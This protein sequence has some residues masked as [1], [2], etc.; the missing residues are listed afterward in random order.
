[1]TRPL[2]S[3]RLGLAV[4]IAALAVT[5]MSLAATAGPAGA[6]TAPAPTTATTSSGS[7]GGSNCIIASCSTVAKGVEC[8]IMPSACVAQAVV[9][10]VSSQVADAVSSMADAMMAALVKG[11]A[12]G[13]TAMFAEVGKFMTG[14][15]TPSVS[16]ADFVSGDGPYHKVAAVSAA[17]MVVF[18]LAS[19]IQGTL[20][21]EPG[22]MLMRF[23]RSAPMA[24]LAIVAFP[25]LVDLAVQ[26]V[27][28]ICSWLLPT[29]AT[30]ETIAKV[31]A[32]DQIQSAA[33]FGLPALLC[34]LFA[35]LGAVLIFAELVVRN[36]LVL[37]T[38]ALAPLS[39]AAMVWTAARSAAR[40]VA[41]LLAGIILSKLAI[42]VALLVGIQLFAKQASSQSGAAYGQMIAGSA[43]LAVA[44]FAPFVVWRMLPLAEA[45]V[46]AHGLSRMPARAAQQGMYT[47]NSAR[48]MA[49]RHGGGGG[50]GGQ[51]SS[52]QSQP[53][54]MQTQSLGN[55]G[56]S[57]SR[58]PSGPSGANGATGATGA[59]G[60]TGSPGAGSSAAGGGAGG[61]AAGG[62]AGGGA[63]GG[64]AAA[65]GAAAGAG[66]AA[67]PVAVPL[68]AAKAAKDK[69]S[70]SADSQSSN[71]GGG[72][73]WGFAP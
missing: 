67:A 25:V 56:G 43:V 26:S 62:A 46:I 37:V 48:S 23:V 17:L 53:G 65:G 54:P 73:G 34:E 11:V 61:G 31:F 12:A 5:V 21:G 18:L 58:G 51:S 9:G 30:M 33:G 24:V 10:G 19:V 4:V 41:E 2:I 16:A 13:A 42:W 15:T 66:A 32:V 20:S 60:A 3:L 7:G 72:S 50:G 71:G 29:G 49:G 8:T 35:F 64:G 63:A 38:V 57:S 1:M 6:Q 27:D 70:S 28:A 14:A 22:Q 55:G 52:G 68:A 40:K 59:K 45:A 47:A 36:A 69:A 39:F 44:I